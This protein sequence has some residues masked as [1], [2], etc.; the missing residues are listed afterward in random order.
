QALMQAV[1]STDP[2]RKRIYTGLKGEIPNPANPPSGC[3]MH[4]RCPLAT[5]RCRAE[6]P[7]MVEHAPGPRAA[8]HHGEQAMARLH[9]QGA[10]EGPRR[11]AGRTKRNHWVIL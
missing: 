5:E 8:W 7:P 9:Q 1:L 2:R 6:V 11:A 10:G 4:P 3:R